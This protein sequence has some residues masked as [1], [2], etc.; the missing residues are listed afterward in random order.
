MVPQEDLTR[1][2][3][4][5]STQGDKLHLREKVMDGEVLTRDDLTKVNGLSDS[6][7]AWVLKAQK[8]FQT[9]GFKRNDLIKLL[10]KSIDLVSGKLPPP[11]LEDLL[12]KP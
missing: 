8:Y 7:Q 12:P 1:L 4:I 6:E 11:Q 2:S 5:L 9:R 10:N 3:L